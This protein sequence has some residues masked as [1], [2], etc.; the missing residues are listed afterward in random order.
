MTLDQ[1][2]E[3]ADLLP[4]EDLYIFNDVLNNR[5]RELKRQELIAT[6]SQS[7][8]EYQEGKAVPA[9]VKDIMNEILS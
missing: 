6:I 9:S 3:E 4:K 8:S 2:L 5:V 1:I 7:C